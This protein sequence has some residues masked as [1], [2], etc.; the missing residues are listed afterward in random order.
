MRS[1]RTTERN[2]GVRAARRADDMDTSPEKRHYKKGLALYPCR[3]GRGKD[4]R[5]H[6]RLATDADRSA[7]WRILEPT[8]RAGETYPCPRDMTEAAAFAYW[9]APANTVFVAEEN[10]EVVGTYYMKP[11]STAGG[12]HVANCGY[13]T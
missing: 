13:M 5:M 2:N 4:A 8:I 6:I 1:A 11:N 3:P 12:A 7:I 10:N 9:F